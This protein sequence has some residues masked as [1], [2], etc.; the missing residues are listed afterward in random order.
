MEAGLWI[1]ANSNKTDIVVTNSHPQIK[2][3]SERETFAVNSM[4]E[5]EL[6]NLSRSNKNFRL[7]IN[8]NE[9]MISY[10]PIFLCCEKYC[11]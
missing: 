6:S 5:E 10:G 3:Y 11:F 1:K 7:I 2:Y 4:T 8:K 9:L